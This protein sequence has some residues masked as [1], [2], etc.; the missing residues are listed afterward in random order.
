MGL[1]F[2]A[3]SAMTFQRDNVSQAQ[4]IASQPSLTIPSPLAKSPTSQQQ[5]A[6]QNVTSAQSQQILS[7]LRPQL[8]QAVQNHTSATGTYRSWQSI[9]ASPGDASSTTVNSSASTAQVQFVNASGTAYSV[10]VPVREYHSAAAN[11]S[12]AT[13]VVAPTSLVTSQVTADC[14][15][16]ILPPQT[17]DDLDGDGLTDTASGTFEVSNAGLESS[18][19]AEFMPIYHISTGEQQSFATF[20]NYVPW[21]VTSLVGTTPPNSYYHVTPLGLATDQSGNQLYA[22]R[23]DYLSLWNADG[24]LV[25]GGAACFYSYFGLDSVI[26]Q[27]SGH[28]LDAERSVMLLAAPAVNGGANTDATQYQIYSLY[29]AAH[30]GTFFDQSIYYDFSPAVPAGEHIIL[31]QSV[32]KHSTYTFNPNY[33]PITPAWFIEAT[34]AAI[35]TEYVDGQIDYETYLLLLAAADDTFYGCLVEQFGD[36]GGQ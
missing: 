18:L 10:T 3:L 20:G 23:V 33:Y 9:I 16:P 2:V 14:C 15:H 21:T 12:G 30:E 7:L 36:Q 28:N 34:N 26:Q 1:V 8:L 31:A 29:T 4:T 22:I 13:G 27:V 19:A 17:L 32:S 6:L 5:T 11:S 35:E 25:G 24:G